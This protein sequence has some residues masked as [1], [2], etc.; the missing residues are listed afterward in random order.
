MTGDAIERVARGTSAYVRL[1]VPS[2]ER[3]ERHFVIRKGGRGRVW[4]G[5]DELEHANRVWSARVNRAAHWGV[6]VARSAFPL[7]IGCAVTLGW[8]VATTREEKIILHPGVIAEL[9]WHPPPTPVSGIPIRWFEHGFRPCTSGWVSLAVETA[10]RCRQA[11]SVLDSRLDFGTPLDGAAHDIASRLQDLGIAC[12]PVWDEISEQSSVVVSRREREELPSPALTPDQTLVWSGRPPLAGF[13]VVTMGHLIV[14]N[15]AGRLLASLGAAVEHVFHPRRPPLDYFGRSMH[16]VPL[17]LEQ[18]RDRAHF[19]ALS[20]RAHA[21][22][23]N[24]RPRVLPNLGLS[25]MPG[26]CAVVSVPAF[27]A[28]SG[29]ALW[30]ALGFQLEAMSGTGLRP[31]DPQHRAVDVAL[32]IV[33]DY[34]MAFLAAARVLTARRNQKY[35]VAQFSALSALA[36][37]SL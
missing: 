14:A 9:A 32:P 8:S 31:R 28:G 11:E 37:H 13:R 16:A 36:K 29:R 12:L 26:D 2:F 35:E 33:S 15:F 34:A 5:Y 1:P 10:A 21:V 18:S 25:P 4:V 22:V 3:K 23:E 19:A 6:D 17:D 30:R 24:F 7:L 27:S 20:D